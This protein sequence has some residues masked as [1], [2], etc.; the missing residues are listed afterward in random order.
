V[1]GLFTREYPP[2]VYG[3]GGVHVEHL[4]RHLR[5][6]S[7]DVRVH[8]I[9]EP[10]PGALAHAPGGYGGN[11]ALDVF[12]AGLSMAAATSPDSGG[13][14]DLVHSHT[15]YANLAG[16]WAALLNDIPHVVTAH[17]LEPLRPWKAQ[18]LGGG[19][20]L[21]TWAEHTAFTRA[22]A[23]IAVSDSM[24]EDILRYYPSVPRDRV[25]VIRNGIDPTQYYSD[26]STQALERHSIDPTRPYVVFVGR[27]TRQ[28]GLTHLLKAAR[29]TRSAAHFVIVADAPD[30]PEAAA[31][32]EALAAA[33]PNVTLIRAK[34][35]VPEVR[36]LLSHA[37]VFCC[38]SV[39]EPLGIVN[40][41]AMAC[42]TAVV[43]TAVGGIPEV[44]DDGV[45]GLLVPG[46]DQPDG[47]SAG[48]EGEGLA[49]HLAE[50]IDEL[51]DD[52][53][54]AVAMGNAGRERAVAH[55]GWDAVAARTA[56]LY[57]ELLH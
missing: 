47:S 5:R 54:R 20:R 26:P 18:Q 8:C 6:H 11:P 45:T 25:H 52:P 2:F 57:G 53:F 4:V 51:V 16:H 34:L 17:S 29:Y 21:S 48:E 24:R 22:D 15:W 31:E 1:V 40:L 49:R 46:P 38:P 10:R 3:G 50:A 56:Q 41:E 28:K 39:Y 43:A 23:L 37:T 19:Y 13:Q 35:P 14:V 27:I 33:Q 9:G 55:F 7:V 30:T 42:G 44:V 12:G 36:Q 32:I